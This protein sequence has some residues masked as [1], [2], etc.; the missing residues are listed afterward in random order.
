MKVL[1]FNSPGPSSLLPT[2]LYHSP[3][4]MHYDNYLCPCL[5]FPL[6]SENLE[7]SRTT[8]LASH[9]GPGSG[10]YLAKSV[11]PSTEEGAQVR[12]SAQVP[13]ADAALAWL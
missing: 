1:R 7:M 9:R 5:L 12:Q 2:S 8:A 6:G 4:Q 13:E 10:K 3:H 11:S